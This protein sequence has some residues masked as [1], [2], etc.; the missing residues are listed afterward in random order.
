[1]KLVPLLIVVTAAHSYRQ[2][3]VT[4]QSAI[5]RFFK[6]ARQKV[7]TAIKFCR[8]KSWAIAVSGRRLLKIAIRPAWLTGAY[9]PKVGTR[10]PRTAMSKARP[11]GR[12]SD[13]DVFLFSICFGL[14]CI[15]GVIIA[16]LFIQIR[17]MKVEIAHWEQNLFATRARL[18][19]VEKIEREKITKEARTLNAQPRQ[20]PVTLSNDDM[21]AIR[22]FI[23]VLPSK[24][25][26]QQKIHAGE[27]ISD[28]TA[29]PVPDSLVNQIPKLRGARFI[30]DE[31]G[32]IIIIGEGSNRADAVIEP[33]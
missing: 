25:G 33:Q 16:A 2:T 29:V 1:M 20:I 24:P 23:K 27:E 5:A 8:D 22:A 30:V 7:A 28:I 9:K 32:A 14:L 26:S 3:F 17:D 6:I 10:V 21:K 13:R 31:N 11:I 15:C 12:T 4:T 18:S 19:Q